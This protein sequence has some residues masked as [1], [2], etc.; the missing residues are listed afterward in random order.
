M[1]PGAGGGTG[2]DPG[3]WDA[4][5]SGCCSVTGTVPGWDRRVEQ[6]YVAAARLATPA[7]REE[8]CLPLC[9]SLG[10]EMVAPS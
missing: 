7:A 4:F 8:P 6:G 5:G 2:S 3:P 10:A 9:G 1:A